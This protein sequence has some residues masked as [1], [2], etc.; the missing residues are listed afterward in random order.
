MAPKHAQRGEGANTY[1]HT[2]IH[3]YKVHLL[4]TGPS[5]GKKNYQ[6]NQYRPNLICCLWEETQMQILRMPHGH[7]PASHDMQTRGRNDQTGR[8]TT[9]HKNIGASPRPIKR[10]GKQINKVPRCSTTQHP[11]HTRSTNA[12]HENEFLYPPRPQVATSE[13]ESTRWSFHPYASPPHKRFFVGCSS[14]FM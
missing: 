5:Q 13:I 12:Q 4:P 2:Y 9:H 3:T 11:A 7:R 6:N 14:P 1:I 10:Y 8:L